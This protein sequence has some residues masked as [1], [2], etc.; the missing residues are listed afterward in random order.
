MSKLENQIPRT[1]SVDC[2]GCHLL[3]IQGYKYSRDLNVVKTNC[4]VPHAIGQH[5]KIVSILSSTHNLD[6]QC[7]YFKITM[8]HNFE[9]V[10]HNQDN[11]LNPIT[12]LWHK[13]TASPI[14]NHK[15]SKYMKLTT[16]VVAQA[17]GYI[18]NEHMFNTFNF[19]KN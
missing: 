8:I 3:P 6:L 15:L 10:M 17:F 9:V 14:L 12:K 4:C 19:M 5:G 13:L 16:I 7:S 1:W 2:L 11:S 18:E